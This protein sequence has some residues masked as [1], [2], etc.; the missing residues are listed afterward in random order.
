M[1]NMELNQVFEVMSNIQAMV[2]AAF[3]A[4][5]ALSQFLIAYFTIKTQRKL[6]AM[7]VYL[8]FRLKAYET[9]ISNL[10]KLV[11]L[12]RESMNASGTIT[13]NEEMR[14]FM[15]SDIHLSHA[16]AIM[17]ASPKLK[18]AIDKCDSVASKLTNAEDEESFDKIFHELNVSVDETV[19]QIQSELKLMI[20]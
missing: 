1:S 4:A 17:F 13:W 18:K 7:D 19:I 20:K 6:K 5:T 3:I 9:H 16:K 14:K 2:A 15:I 8:E 10:Y 12:I 11:R